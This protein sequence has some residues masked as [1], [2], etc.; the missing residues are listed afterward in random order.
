MNAKK[1]KNKMSSVR[2]LQ[3][4]IRLL[5]EKK[6]DYVKDILILKSAFSLIDE[7]FIKEMENAELNKKYWFRRYFCFGYGMK[8][9]TKDPR[10][11]NEFIKDIMNPY[12]SGEGKEIHF[13]REYNKIKKE[14]DNNNKANFAATNRLIKNNI[15]L[16]N[17]IYNKMEEGIKNTE[18][19]N[20]D[21]HKKSIYESFY[22][23]KLNWTH[24]LINLKEPETKESIKI[25]YEEY[26]EIIFPRHNSDS[27]MSEMDTN[28]YKMKS[29]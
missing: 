7:M 18:Q 24:S 4:K 28:V 29:K 17:T 12:G 8:E 15:H 6:I 21:I 2:K 14:I 9:I 27:S 1:Q 16:S 19:S 20:N 25:N 22:P 26:D 5:Y 3:D 23:T 13:L 10:E 11:L